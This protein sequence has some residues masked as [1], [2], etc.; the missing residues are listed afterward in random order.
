MRRRRF[1]R[2]PRKLTR[3]GEMCWKN[4]PILNFFSPGG[5]QM[6]IFVV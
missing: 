3:M 4:F 5:W 2:R 6:A 1:Q